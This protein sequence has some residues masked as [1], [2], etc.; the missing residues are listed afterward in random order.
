M[1]LPSVPT[2]NLQ[3]PSLTSLLVGWIILGAIVAGVTFFRS[4]ETPV[5]AVV[6]AVIALPLIYFLYRYVQYRRNAPPEEETKYT[7]RQLAVLTIGAAMFVGFLG[8]MA[9][10]E[11]W[12]VPEISVSNCQ[13]LAIRLRVD[14]STVEKCN[15]LV[16]RD[17]IRTNT[18]VFRQPDG[19]YIDWAPA[20]EEAVLQ[21]A[22]I[23]TLDY[24]AFNVARTKYEAS[25][26]E[27]RTNRLTVPAN[28]QANIWLA[29]A[30]IAALATL[31]PV[32]PWRAKK[33]FTVMS[34]G[35]IIPPAL[36][37]SGQFGLAI[38]WL[39]I[40]PYQG[41]DE[42]AA[43][44]QSFRA[45]FVWAI[46]A[47]VLPV[48]GKAIAPA[49]A[50]AMMRSERVETT[51]LRYGVV[52]LYGLILGAFLAPVII[53]V[54]VPAAINAA[55]GVETLTLSVTLNSM[56]LGVISAGALIVSASKMLSAFAEGFLI[57]FF[58]P[59]PKR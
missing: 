4:G 21:T 45:G 20:Q 18:V 3:K 36:L 16:A 9:G 27:F 11:R 26:G 50:G 47:V 42:A 8:L 2:I 14:P 53:L 7:G 5:G 22:S 25:L 15:P 38:P 34:A 43:I 32:L 12:I 58:G 39:G 24:A 30:L 33:L 56:T 59:P 52:G 37:Y 35:I 57:L 19:T 44:W 6:F 1:K 10:T 23:G 54:S 28:T 46:F 31:A 17:L 48:V 41:I 40:L 13:L 51:P 29:A 49:I 55:A